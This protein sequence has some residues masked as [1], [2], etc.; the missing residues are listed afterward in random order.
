MSFY[1]LYLSISLVTIIFYY[2]TTT[3]NDL[4]QE[5]NIGIIILPYL[6]FTNCSNDV[7]SCTRTFQIMCCVHCHVSLFPLIEN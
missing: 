2:S 7:L 4:D 5:I 3:H 1:T 6:D